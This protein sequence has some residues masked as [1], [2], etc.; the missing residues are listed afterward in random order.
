MMSRR[1]AEKESQII[2]K[3]RYQEFEK[4]AFKDIPE[5]RFYLR[6]LRNQDSQSKLDKYCYVHLPDLGDDNLILLLISFRCFERF[7]DILEE[8]IL[9]A[10]FAKNRLEKSKQV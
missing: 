1:K 8:K 9:A 5:A 6:E 2:L 7:L 3:K 10:S 4:T